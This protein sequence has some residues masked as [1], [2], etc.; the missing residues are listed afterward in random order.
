MF[1]YAHNKWRVA[2]LAVI[3]SV[4]A[5]FPQFLPSAKSPYGQLSLV[6]LLV[7]FAFGVGAVVSIVGIQAINPRSEKIWLPPR[8]DANPFSMTQPLQWFH[9]LAVSMIVT[10][11]AALG[12]M[13][14]IATAGLEP[15]I[16]FFL[17]LG[18]LGGV[19]GCETLYR[20]KFRAGTTDSN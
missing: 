4:A 12:W 17:G 20:H 18:L 11:V 5:C 15:L 13:L 14:V 8:W 16:P 19:R 6:W 7:L 9:L 1:I 2:R 10:G 3:V